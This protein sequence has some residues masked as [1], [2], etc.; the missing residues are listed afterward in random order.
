VI[1]DKRKLNETENIQQSCV[2]EVTEGAGVP[3]QCA[4]EIKA[5]ESRCGCGATWLKKA[6]PLGAELR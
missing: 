4:G 1:A 5:G 6:Q 3:A 2:V